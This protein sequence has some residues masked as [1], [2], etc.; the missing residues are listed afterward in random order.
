M[1]KRRVVQS[2]AAVLGI[3]AILT[4]CGGKEQA[5][6]EPASQGSEAV[7]AE[8]SGEGGGEASG[9]QVEL[10][11]SWWGS[12]ARHEATLE[13]L[14]LFMEKHPNIKVTAEY[15]GFDGYHDKLM[16]QISSGTEPD[17]YQLDNN[18]Y[19][20]NLAANDK[21]GDLTPYI[22][23]ELK[24]D[25][26]PESALTWAQY[27]GVQYGVPSGLNGPLFIWNKNL[28]DAAGVAYPT[29]DWS[30]EDFE[31]ACQEIYDKTGV[32]GMKEP[33]YFLT[34]TMTRQF[35]NWF[36]TEEGEL[37]D[38]REG[39]AKTYEK[40]NK[41][42]ETGVFPPLDM[43]VGQESQQDNLFL[44]CDAACEV[45]HIAT[46]PQD[47][48][49][50]AEEAELGVSLVPGTKQNGGAYMLASMP[51]TLGKSSQ[52][53]KEAATLIDFLINDKDAAKILMTVRGVPAPESVRELITPM[54]EG[55]PLLVVQGVD[56]LI[57]NTERIDYEWLIPG[58]AVI[59]NTIMDEQYATGYGQKTP[60]EAAEDTYNTI[61]EAVN[62][63]K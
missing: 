42:R 54:L 5:A 23:K 27:N 30:W 41:W 13:V 50:M 62:S 26:Y 38:F 12:D 63:S 20:A 2:A 59:E 57:E 21:L 39:L 7:S 22:G 56:L 25:D 37:L 45:N 48:A 4:A 28:F 9:E 11:V 10:R 14:D 8:A 34:M 32:Y 19:F 46:M 17:V 40:Y 16:T 53:P 36:G 15:Q 51:W 60:Q 33:S 18:V 55:D 35:G 58:S 31:K 43:T 24:L 49:A 6:S 52:H 44:S 3:A 47:H 61:L 1:K 29:D